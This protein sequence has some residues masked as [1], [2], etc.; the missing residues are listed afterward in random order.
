MGR[1][2]QLAQNKIFVRLRLTWKAKQSFITNYVTE[3]STNQ[4]RQGAN[5]S[6]ARDLQVSAG[7]NRPTPCLSRPAQGLCRSAQGLCRR[8]IVLSRSAPGSPNSRFKL[9]LLYYYSHP[10]IGSFRYHNKVNPTQTGLFR[11]WG[12]WGGGSKWPTLF[13]R[14]IT[15]EIYEIWSSLLACNFFT[16]IPIQ[17]PNFTIFR[18]RRRLHR[19]KQ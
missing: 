6:R 17:K 8:A 4:I 10:N 3:Q 15:A 16:A 7:H 18:W 11:I 19:H 13:Y 12:D 14:R 9:R 2:I 5:S 1:P